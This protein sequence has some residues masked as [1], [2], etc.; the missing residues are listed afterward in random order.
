MEVHRK[1]AKNKTLQA[2]ETKNKTLQAVEAKNKTL[3]VHSL[4]KK[5]VEKSSQVPA[6]VN[7]LDCQKGDVGVNLSSATRIKKR[8]YVFY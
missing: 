7:T 8:F 5:T 2:M 6:F 3:Q 4:I 1:E